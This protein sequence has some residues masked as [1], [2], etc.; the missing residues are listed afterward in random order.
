MK[1]IKAIIDPAM[2][3]SVMSA[4]HRLPHFPGVTVSDAQGQGRGE[5]PG[6][7]YVP[8]GPSW[9]FA[10]KIKLEIFCSDAQCDELIN[11]IRVNSQ[12]GDAAH[13]IIM[14]VDLDRVIRTRTGQEQDDAV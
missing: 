9:S 13:G 11:A 4:L 7:K 12:R 5:G 14:V 2:L 1:E 6:G 8:H 10:K 3:S